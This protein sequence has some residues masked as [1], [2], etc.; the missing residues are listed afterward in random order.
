MQTQTTS[1]NSGATAIKYDPYDFEVDADPYPVWKR[2]RDEAPLY[3]NDEYKFW[4]LTRYEDVSASL[5]DFKT[6]SS[7][8]GTILEMIANNATVPPGLMIFEDP[9]LHTIHRK[10]LARLFTPRQMSRLEPK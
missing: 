4:A 10:I 3:R 8:K 5:K 6:Y 1:E 9:P 7:A 2:M